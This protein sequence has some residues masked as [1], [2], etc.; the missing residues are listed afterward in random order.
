[1]LGQ[2]YVLKSPTHPELGVYVGSTM[3]PLSTRFSM[4][5]ASFRRYLKGFGNW[6][7]SF[8]LFEKA[9][10]IQIELYEECQC[11]RRAEL[12]RREGEVMRLHGSGCV[13]HNVAGRG[14]REYYADN[15]AHLV[16]Y[17]RDW[18][19][20]RGGREKKAAHYQENKER[21]KE[22]SLARYYAKKAA[23]VN[24]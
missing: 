11:E 6:V 21:L 7:T 17:A 13:N 19:Q 3:K 12:T 5:K 23:L 24:G 4:H 2:I 15:Q 9:G 20:K 8:S 22:A 14:M 10:D 16:A 18:Y 1:M